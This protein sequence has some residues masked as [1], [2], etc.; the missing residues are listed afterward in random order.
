VYTTLV[1]MGLMVF[2]VFALM[3]MSTTAITVREA[4]GGRIGWSLGGHPVRLHAGAR[5]GVGL[6][7][8]TLI[9][10]L[11]IGGAALFLATRVLASVRRLRA[12]SRQMSAG[13][14]SG[15][16]CSPTA[17]PRNWDELAS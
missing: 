17:S 14:D 16:G 15:C 8:S 2:Y 13:C 11:V 3:C 7:A 6:M 12:A 5:V 9:V 1:A 4:G 10:A